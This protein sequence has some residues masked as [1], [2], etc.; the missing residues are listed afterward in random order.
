[1]TTPLAFDQLYARV[2]AQAELERRIAASKMEGDRRITAFDERMAAAQAQAHER[3]QALER[4]RMQWKPEAD[5]RAAAADRRAENLEGPMPQFQKIEP[6]TI[7]WTADWMQVNLSPGDRFARN[8]VEPAVIDLFQAQG[9]RVTT[10]YPCARTLREGLALQIDILVVEEGEVVLVDCE[11]HLSRDQVDEFVGKIQLFKQ[12]FP[13]YSS[14]QT[15]G[16][17]AAI[18]VQDGVETYLH[19]QGLF[20][21]RPVGSQ[22]TITGVAIT[23]SPQ[24]QPRIW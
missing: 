23:N 10:V 6:C 22:T 24:F 16:A 21:I 5:R 17:V 4:H 8:F 18:E 1:M 11:D 19:D 2:R 3:D 12:A 13:H 9:L 20:I 7:D 14:Y 15:Y